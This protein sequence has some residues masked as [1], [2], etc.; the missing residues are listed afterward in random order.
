MLPKYRQFFFGMFAFF[1]LSA[2][3]NTP[4]QAPLSENSQTVLPKT[5]VSYAKN[6]SISYFDG[7]KVLSFFNYSPNSSDTLHFVLLKKE[8]A[9]PKG[10]QPNQVIYIPV[11]K[12]ATTSTTQIAQLDTLGF[13]DKIVGVTDLNFISEPKILEKVAQKKVFQMGSEGNLLAENLLQAQTELLLMSSFSEKES[14][15]IRQF[16]QLGIKVLPIADWLENHP[17][18]RTEWLKVLAALFDQ[19]QKAEKIVEGIKNNYL[20]TKDLASKTSTRP[21][22]FRGLPYKNTWYVAGGKS[23]IAQ[24]LADAGATYTWQND[25]STGSLSLDFEAVYPIALKADFWL[26]IGDIANKKALLGMDKR[27]EKFE[28]Y[29]K[30]AIF[31]DNKKINA[32]GESDYYTKGVNNPHLILAD[33]VKI[34]H[35]EALPNYQSVYFKKID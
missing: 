32:K 10:F 27:F 3:Q 22:V 11:Q 15:Q 6:F 26:L 16:E 4:T 21:S 23:Y 31:S 7:Y 8:A 17:L 33:F 13:L 20:T 9:V 2:C 12:I 14:N 30:N 18:G 29:Q 1:L 34:F 24:L 28:A 25:Q 19:E 35:P 5:T